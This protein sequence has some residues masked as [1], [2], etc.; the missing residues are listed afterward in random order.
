MIVVSKNQ[1]LKP[2]ADRTAVWID[3]IPPAGA[4]W[5]PTRAQR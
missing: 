5:D 2:S 1:R 3:N 4:S